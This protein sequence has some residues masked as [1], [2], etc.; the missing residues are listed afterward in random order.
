MLRRGLER[1]V[2]AVDGVE[3]PIHQRDR[4]IHHRKAERPLLRRFLGRLA[5]RGNEVARHR[6]ADDLVDELEP[7]AARARGDVDLHVGELAVPAGL[8]FSRPCSCTARRIVS[9]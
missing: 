9:L 1:H 5:D 7:G 6:A 4:D 2:G 8:R 3:L